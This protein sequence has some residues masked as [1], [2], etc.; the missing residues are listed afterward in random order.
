MGK[1]NK[2]IRVVVHLGPEKTGTTALAKYLTVLNSRGELPSGYTYPTGDQWFHRSDRIQKHRVELERLTE[3]LKS[4]NSLSKEDDAVLRGLANS[5]RAT[6]GNQTTILVAETSL[7][8]INPQDLNS[9]LLRYFDRVDYVVAARQ[10][11]TGIRSLIAQR[12]R[13]ISRP[14]FSLNPRDYKGSDKINFACMDYEAVATAWNSQ[15][16]RVQ[17]HFLPYFEDDAASFAF[18]DRFFSLLG[19]KR[20]DGVNGIDGVRIHPTFSEDGMK[21]LAQIKKVKKT[22]GWIPGVKQKCDK[23]FAREWKIFHNSAAQGSIEPSGKF[24]QPWNFSEEDIQW[25]SSYFYDSN[26]HFLKNVDRSGFEK[27]WASWEKS[28]LSTQQTRNN[29]DT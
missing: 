16:E 24:Y 12:V 23:D 1:F 26:A 17:L 10:Q 25:I 5:L 4:G 20:P 21:K 2:G 28:V 3:V 27:E 14:E 8:S 22:W 7:I 6:S 9:L 19:T 15:D 11:V 18:I 13:D 29:E